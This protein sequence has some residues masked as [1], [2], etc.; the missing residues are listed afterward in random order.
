MGGIGAERLSLVYMTQQPALA[1]HGGG[2]VIM[3]L[4]EELAARGH[5]CTVV[6]T[7]FKPRPGSS[8]R[9]RLVL[10]EKTEC[11]PTRRS[12]LFLE[13]ERKRV[14]YLMV[15]S[16]LVAV[17]ALWAIGLDAAHLSTVL[18]WAARK[19]A[20]E[21]SIVLTDAHPAVQSAAG[22][23]GR[24]V[25]P[26]IQLS[27][28][29]PFGPAAR[30][31]GREKELEPYRRCDAYIAFSD[32]SA[33]IIRDG[34]GIH[35]IVL[36]CPEAVFDV[37]PDAPP[38]DHSSA[39]LVLMINVGFLKGAS[40]FMELAR[41]LPEVRFGAVISWNTTRDVLRQL[42]HLPNVE[43]IDFVR[44]VD[45]LYRKARVLLVPSLLPE[46]SPLVGVEAMARGIPV[47]AAD[48]AGLR[49]ASM[50]VPYLL[51][52]RPAVW[53]DRIPDQDVGPWLDALKRLLGDRAHYDDVSRR[54]RMAARAYLTRGRTTAD[55]FE[56]ALREVRDGRM[57][58]PRP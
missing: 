35:P 31:R 24:P 3:A 22:R 55:R 13:T 2:K 54:S 15:D 23:L 25:V 4:F 34:L 43:V 29:L 42:S 49:E 10:D 1:Q 21:D 36:P 58:P 50:S 33:S 12:W 18:G 26:I 47:M 11:G 17:V 40:I 51:P 39:E 41:Q 52:V 27:R 5:D 6:G 38:D 8:H 30:R 46:M 28:Y 45:S 16:P 9:A 56:A 37:S 57:A 19:V 7:R 20:K 53:G 48:N 44:D 32:Y 14:R